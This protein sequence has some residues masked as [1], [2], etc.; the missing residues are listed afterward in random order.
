MTT[1][2]RNCSA[3]YATP[4]SGGRCP[5]CASPRLIAHSALAE[6]AIAHI[7]CD[8]FY[9]TVEKRERPELADRP[10]IVGGGKRGVV[11]ACCYVARLYGVRSAM[12]MFQALAACPD[13]Q[14]IRPNMAKYR[15]VGR[16]VRDEM[17]RSTPLVEPISIDEAFL[18]LSGTETLHDALPAQRL[19]S[20][21][22]TVEAKFGITL[23]IGLSDNKFLAKIASDLDKP[24]GFAVLCRS[25]ATVFFADKPVSLLWGVGAATQRRLAAD[26][27]TRVGQLALLGERELASRYGRIGAH[28]G[29]LARGI[30]DRVV[31]AHLPARS[32]SAE[33]TLARDEAGAAILAQILRPLCERVSQH[34]KEASLAAGTVTLKLKTADFRLRTRSRRLA[35]PTQLAETIFR[36]GSGL[37][38]GEANGASAFRLIGIAADMLVDGAKADLP[39]LFERELGRVRRLERAIDG[40]RERLGRDALSWGE[41]A[42]GAAAAAGETISRTARDNRG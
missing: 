29:R 39:T 1:L 41:T 16:A 31:Q 20:L 5:Q 37:L 42:T 24:R 35:E 11:L 15:E 28:L 36:I 25:E 6:L 22:R 2:C 33:T 26:G 30:D 21:A 9:A 13:A 38:A 19:A 27:I 14:V 17:R 3:L 34:L 10:V 8:A 4:P 23:S 40:I 32:I 12:P 7:D 18:D